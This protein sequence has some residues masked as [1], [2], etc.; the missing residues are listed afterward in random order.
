MFLGV[1]ETIVGLH[2]CGAGIVQGFFQSFELRHWVIA[3]SILNT[4][5]YILFLPLFTL[6]PR[7]SRLAKKK[8]PIQRGRMPYLTSQK[9]SSL[10]TLFR[11]QRA[12]NS[13]SIKGN[14]S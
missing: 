7:F 10:A 14:W 9:T 5:K 11:N 6:H 1:A 3:T 13:R 4:R 2:Y 12:S 8:S